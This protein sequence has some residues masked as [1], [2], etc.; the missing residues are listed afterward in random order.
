[1][2]RRYRSASAAF[3]SYRIRRNS[4]IFFSS[5]SSSIDLLTLSVG[6]FELLEAGVSP[7]T[8]IEVSYSG[9]GA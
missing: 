6:A 9:G 1:M 7:P 2:L 5:A 8:I 3:A 4:Y